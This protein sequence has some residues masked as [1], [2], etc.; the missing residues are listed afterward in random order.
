M[1]KKRFH[2]MKDMRGP[3]VTFDMFGQLYFT[4][5][6]ITKIAYR[7]N[8]KYLLLIYFGSC[9]VNVDLSW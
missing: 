7:I 9:P 2:K 8:R 1:V 4:F 3:K 5:R 6:E